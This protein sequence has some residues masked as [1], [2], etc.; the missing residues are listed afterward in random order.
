MNKTIRVI[1]AK[2][3]RCKD[4]G[5]TCS[6]YGSIPFANYDIELNGYTWQLIGHDGTMTVGLCRQ[7]TACL[8]TAEE[9]AQNYADKT[10][11][12]KLQAKIN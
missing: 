6:I 1:E 3:A 5:K 7:P 11:Y 12:T 2:R 4:T 9:I 8:T 10:G